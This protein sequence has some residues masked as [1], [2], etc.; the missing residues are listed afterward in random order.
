MPAQT[1]T[2]MFIFTEPMSRPSARKSAKAK[3]EVRS[4]VTTIQ[5]RRRKQQ[6]QQQQKQQERLVVETAR[7]R[8]EEAERSLP[9]TTSELVKRERG[10]EVYVVVGEGGSEEESPPPPASPSQSQ[11]VASANQILT[12][13]IST[14]ADLFNPLT[15]P[16]RDGSLALQLFLLDDSSN[17]VMTT[18]SDL[19]TDLPSVMVSEPQKEEEEEENTTS[20]KIDAC[21]ERQRYTILIR[22]S[23]PFRKPTSPSPSTTPS[24]TSRNTP[25]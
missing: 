9:E 20:W 4:H 2:P 3:K 22:L 12:P 7:Q 21:E 16:F 1:A 17:H 24:P 5:H 19:G 18:L 10:K 25:T 15:S 11:P 8:E 14:S 13:N 23:L 6:Q